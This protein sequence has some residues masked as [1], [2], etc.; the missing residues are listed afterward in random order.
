MDVSFIM[1][2]TSELHTRP[3]RGKVDILNS[4]CGENYINKL[5]YS[6]IGLL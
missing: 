2:P 6:F 3:C 4:F 1:F 5:I